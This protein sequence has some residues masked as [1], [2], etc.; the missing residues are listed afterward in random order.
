MYIRWL[1]FSPDLLSLY[2]AVHFLSR[3]FSSI[4]SIMENPSLEL[5]FR[6]AS[7]S[8]GQQLSPGLHGLLDEVYDIMWYFVHYETV[9]YPA[10]WDHIICLFV[11][12]PG[13]S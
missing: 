9:Y 1:I 10:L 13:H 7:S 2:P 6:Y 3:W 11:V 5:C 12:N 4:M 8:C